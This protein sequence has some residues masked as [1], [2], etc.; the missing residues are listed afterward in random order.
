MKINLRKKAT[1]AILLMALILCGTA[2]CV[3]YKIHSS[4]MDKYYR[5]LAKNIASTTAVTLD[6]KTVQKYTDAVKEIYL[7]NPMPEFNTPEEEAAYYEQYEDIVDEQYR[8]LFDKMSSIKKSNVVSYLYII[9]IDPE[10]RT[11]VYIIDADKTEKR[12]P[13]GTWEPLK[14]NNYNVLTNP[15][16]GF[17]SF[18]SNTEKYGWL[19]SSGTAI[20]DDNG[21]VIAY[22][23]VDLSMDEVMNERYDFLKMLCIIMTVITIIILVTFILLI[24]HSVVIPINRLSQNARSFVDKMNS[25]GDDRGESVFSDL[26]IRSGDEIENLLESFKFM[27]K[28]IYEYIDNLSRITSEKERISAELNIANKIQADMLPS[29]FPAFPDRKEFD[30]YATMNPAKKVGGDFYDFFMV[31]DRHLAIVIADV[32]GKGIPAALFMVIGKTLIKD[33]TQ[34]KLEPDKVFNRVN[35]LLCESNKEGLFITAFEGVL[36]L[37]T[38]EFIYVNAGHE[39]PYICRKGDK[40]RLHELEPDFVLAGMEDMSYVTGRVELNEGDRIF[41]F[42]DGVTDA[43]N[44][45]EEL[46]GFKRLEAVLNRN[47]D[48]KPMDL[49]HTIKADIDSFVGEAAQFDDITMLCVEYKHKMEV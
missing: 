46:Y 39:C 7:E 14:E 38:G 12:C 2:I 24:N 35:N 4:I 8:Y 18:I 32:S 26:N 36:D 44:L 45:Q 41:Q 10:T 31:D 6:A 47:T 21:Q 43:I 42:T 20:M 48:S 9:Y 29:I 30:I 34:A 17:D 3:S 1:A 16:D 22:A 37:A 19:C 23:V 49:L 28:E 33:H 13:I 27:E 11:A 15:E 5:E 25:K 40:Y